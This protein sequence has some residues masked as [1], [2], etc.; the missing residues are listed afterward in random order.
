MKR[1]I[2]MGFTLVELLI[3]IALIAI[4]SVAV[5]ATINPIEQAN[6][7]RDAG[8]QNDAAEVLNALERYYASQNAYP[9]NN[10]AFG[11]NTVVQGNVYAL[12]SDDTRFGI[13]GAALVGGVEPIVSDGL[14]AG[15]LISTS[16]LKTAFAGKPY[17]TE[18]LTL[19]VNMVDAMYVVNNG[20][21]SNYVCYVPKANATRIKTS[22]LMCLTAVGA[23]AHLW[24]YNP[25]G[26][27]S[28]VSDWVATNGFM[29]PN[30]SHAFLI[31]VP[32]LAAPGF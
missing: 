15:T 8:V 12:R 30:A 1:A 13:L 3:V 9:W 29:K 7:A 2:R 31:C 22:Q 17:F 23:G 5:L 16:E 19:A 28:S 14:T 4:L 32:S 18:D 24:T 11:A 26:A 10:A 27:C 25:T 20:K 6:K 21:D